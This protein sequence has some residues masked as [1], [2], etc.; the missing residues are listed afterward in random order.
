MTIS[1][2]ALAATIAV[3]FWLAVAHPLIAAAW[4]V[5]VTMVTLVVWAF[6]ETAREAE[7][8]LVLERKEAEARRRLGSTARVPALDPLFV[9]FPIWTET[10][11][12]DGVRPFQWTS[13]GDRFDHLPGVLVLEQRGAEVAER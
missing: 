3:F 8:D 10:L 11:T 9:A 4:F 13:S 2:L 12:H 5:L 1:L 7:V 6:A